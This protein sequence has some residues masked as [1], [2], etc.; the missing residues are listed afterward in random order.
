M[1]RKIAVG[2][3]LAFLVSLGLLV[4]AA[5]RHGFSAREKPSRIGA[6]LARH[7]RR[8]ATPS[9]AKTMRN[10]HASTPEI[11]AE[12]R[13]HFADH[14]AICHGNDG[15]GNATIG[16][17]LYP[18]VPDMTD[19]ETQKLTD[20]ELFYIISNGVRFTGMPAWG[21]EDTPEEMWKLVLFIRHLPQITPDELKLMEMGEGEAQDEHTG[22]EAGAA[23]EKRG[24]PPQHKHSK[25]H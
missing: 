21:D 15:R 25:P 17:N 14:C 1:R 11:L 23:E 9:G 7:A 22:E 13:N 16:R 19:G 10:P 6:F 20:G 5:L 4:V 18:K 3:A 12:A 2:V 8:I 24:Q